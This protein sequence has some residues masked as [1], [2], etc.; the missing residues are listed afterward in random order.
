MDTPIDTPSSEPSAPSA[1]ERKGQRITVRI[2]SGDLARLHSESKR[3]GLTVGGV[4]RRLIR[5]GLNHTD[6]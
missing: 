1:D 6:R 5:E 2:S 3:A 4:I